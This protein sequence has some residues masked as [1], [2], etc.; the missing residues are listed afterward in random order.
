MENSIETQSENEETTITVSVT[1]DMRS[2]WQETARLL[3]L[4]KITDA[5]KIAMDRVRVEED[6]RLANS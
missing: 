2:K 6:Q 5:I 1:K 3:G 4:K